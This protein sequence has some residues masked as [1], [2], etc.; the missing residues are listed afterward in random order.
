MGEWRGKRVREIGR[1]LGENV[2]DLRSVLGARLAHD[3]TRRLR[4]SYKRK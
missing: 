3:K 1:T 4:H 2:D